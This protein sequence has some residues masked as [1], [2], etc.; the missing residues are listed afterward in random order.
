MQHTISEQEQGQRLDNYLLR[1]WRGVPRSL[2]YRLIR[3]GKV[4]LNAARTTPASRLHSGDILHLPDNIVTSSPPKPPAKALALP[5]LYEDSELLAVDKPAGLAVHGGSGIAHGVI[6]RLRTGRGLDRDRNFLELAH[7]LDRET[8][9]VLLLAKKRSALR[10]VQAQWRAQQVQKEYIALVFGDWQKRHRRIV[11][12][13]RR[14]GGDSGI[15]RVVT[16]NDGKAALTQTRL[17][18]QWRRG[19]LISAVL[20]TGRTHQLRVHFAE[21]GIPIAGDDKYGIFADNHALARAGFARMFLHAG[22]LRFIR[23]ATGA[24]LMIESPLPPLFEHAGAYLDS[25]EK[26]T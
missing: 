12:P 4:K 18:R 21:S 9:G 19:A 24:A 14:I 1:E 25:G 2:I 3:T 7:R 22:H 26:C 16:D 8:S 23:P 5:V 10:M 15:R 17:L 13:L 11:L 6:E 20:A